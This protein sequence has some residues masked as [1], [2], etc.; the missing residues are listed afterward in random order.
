MHLEQLDVKTTFLHG[1]FVEE[2]YIQQPQGYEVKGKEKLVCKLR[3]SVY[4][5]KQSLR[6]W[7]LKFDMFMYEHDCTRGH[8]DHF[9]YLKK[10]NNGKYIILLLYVD[11]MLVVGSNTREINVLK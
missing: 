6:Q 8:S 11:V 7:Y 3:K 10:K 2:I 1:D 4:G 5:L 9:V